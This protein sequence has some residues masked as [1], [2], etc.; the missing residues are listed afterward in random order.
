MVARSPST[1]L[2]T[3]TG[4]IFVTV[5]AVQL[6]T[7]VGNSGLQSVLPA[8]GRQIGIP[9]PLVA[10]IFSLSALLWTV[11]APFWARVSDTRG[12]KPMMLLGLFG[13]AVSMTGC[14]TV[15]WFGLQRVLAPLVVFAGFALLRAIF[16]LI[17]SAATP[18]SQA[19]VADRT[20]PE[21][22]TEALSQ[23]AGA[24]GLGTIAGPAIAP[25]FVLAVVG[26]AG[27][28]FAFAA[29]ALLVLAAVW[30]LVPE[31]RPP[32]AFVADPALPFSPAEK[33]PGLWRDPA[34]RRS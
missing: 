9:D 10:A 12:R 18:A 2:G 4:P 30:R 14:A 6:V 23:L 31:R 20:P 27:P 25:I 33:R 29:L 28:M 32:S 1:S 22:R 11:S 15:V 26:L 17:G 19:Y 13:Y 16:G 21:A 7:A 3:L 24:F 34:V 8:I 5:F